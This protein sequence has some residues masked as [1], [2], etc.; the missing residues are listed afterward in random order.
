MPAFTCHQIEN[1]CS[2]AN[3]F[4]L[5]DVCALESSSLHGC[6]VVGARPSNRKREN[7]GLVIRSRHCARVRPPTRAPVSLVG[8]GV[9]PSSTHPHSTHRRDR[10][11]RS[12]IYVWSTTADRRQNRFLRSSD[13]CYAAEDWWSVGYVGV[14]ICDSIGVIA[15]LRRTMT[16]LEWSNFPLTRKCVSFPLNFLWDRNTRL[17]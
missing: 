4:A 13:K 2:W 6:G 1:L 9:T 7:G 12:R 11:Y 3:F 14:R 15:R 5:C 8:P 10:T 17:P 16:V